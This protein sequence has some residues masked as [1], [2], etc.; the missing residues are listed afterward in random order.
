MAIFLDTETTGLSPENGDAI[1]ELAIVNAI[2]QPLINTLVNPERQIPSRA[3]AVHGITNEMVRRQPTL[4]QLMPRISDIV[5][6]EIVVIYNS[7]FDTKFFPGRLRKARS[8]EC[9]MRR[10]SATTGANRWPTL[11]MAARHVGHSWTG[12]AHRA[13]ADALACR[14]VWNWLQLSEHRTTHARTPEGDIY[15]TQRSIEKNSG[16]RQTTSTT[17][18]DTEVSQASENALFKST[19][20]NLRP[21]K[22]WRKIDEGLLNKQTGEL[23]PIEYLSLESSSVQGF[24]V[25]SF[26]F[27][28]VWIQLSEV[29]DA[30]P[31]SHSE[32]LPK[33]LPGPTAAAVIPVSRQANL[34][35]K[36]RWKKVD[37]ALINNQSGELI[38]LEYLKLQSSGIPGFAVQSF[39]FS[40]TW[41]LLS[42]IE[43]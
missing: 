40:T 24:A 14:S 20:D 43:D 22:R 17:L 26:M 5:T 32:P 4:S 35:P 1:V 38:P 37:A 39:N 10:F 29:E 34:I 31:P 28:T 8:V 11:D 15:S 6:D 13:L 7:T 9:A 23:I 33:P 36:K 12:H 3:T 18:A 2:G 16:Q 27:S 42:E 25:K 41:I 21:K 19:Y 30:R